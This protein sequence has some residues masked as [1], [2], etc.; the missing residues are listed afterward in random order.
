M[1]KD[2]IMRMRKFLSALCVTALGASVA[3]VGAAPSFAAPMSLAR[4]S[5]A[6][7]MTS[8]S[9]VVQIREGDRWKKN[10]SGKRY[11][12]R[13][14]N[15]SYYK[16]HNN[17]WQGSNRHYGHRHGW[18]NGYQGYRYKRNGYRYYNGYWFPAAAFIAGAVIGGAI[19]N[20]GGRR[21]GSSH[22]QWCYDRYRSYRASDNTF[23]P[24]N[25]PRQQCYSPYR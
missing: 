7:P 25:G 20:D 12:K 8:Q 14:G 17:N 18:H 5:V 3:L 11:Y 21:V 19:A 9:D 1:K 16:R 24:Y 15:N 6:T 13:Q 23:Q 2:Y 4:S 22:V 10:K